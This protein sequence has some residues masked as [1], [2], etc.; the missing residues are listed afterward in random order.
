[1]MPH[2]LPAPLHRALL[3]LAHLVRHYW[4]RW[5]GAPIAGVSV[6]I[7]NLNGDVLLLKHSYGPEVWGL[8]GGGLKSGEDPFAAAHREVCEEIG[9]TLARIEAIGVIEEVISGAPH[10]RT[11]GPHNPRPDRGVARAGDRGTPLNQPQLR[12][13]ARRFA[14]ICPFKVPQSQPH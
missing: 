8:P 12:F 3:P 7:T 11:A 9:I 6:I 4:R 5:R 14:L 1:M 13:V 2:A 10:T